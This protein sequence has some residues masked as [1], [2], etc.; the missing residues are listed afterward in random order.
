MQSTAVRNCIRCQRPLGEGLFCEY[1]GTFVLDSEG[2]IV[3]AGRGERILAWL[4]S[5]L[6]LIFTLFIG[7]V[8]W[9]FLV[10][11]RGQNPGKAVVGIRVIRTN[12][13]AVGT[14]GMFVR[15][16]AGQLAGLIPLYLDDLWI[17]WDR[18]AQT[19]HDKLVNTVVVRA[20][21]SEKIVERGGLGA[22]PEGVTPPPIYGPPI[23]FSSAPSPGS[24]PPAGPPAPDTPAMAL[25]RLA[26][27]RGKD[28]ITE[29]EYQEKRRAII[30]QL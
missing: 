20:Q 27:L 3:M 10:A 4:I 30:D 19:L 21:G 18:D 5:A 17:L 12:G 9:W 28:L 8:I 26:E 1:D 14:G 23:R 7:W 22:L 15:G 2:T 6:I 11:P 24:T 16:L 25:V 13:D 29:E